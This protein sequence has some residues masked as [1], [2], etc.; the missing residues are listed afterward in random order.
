MF[1]EPLKV[2]S[3]PRNFPI[4]LNSVLSGSV[5]TSKLFLALGLFKELIISVPTFSLYFIVEFG[6]MQSI[7]ND[8]LRNSP[9]KIRLG[10]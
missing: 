5:P 4:Y 10:H 1:D 3:L 6:N 7:E 2:F 9:L 8:S